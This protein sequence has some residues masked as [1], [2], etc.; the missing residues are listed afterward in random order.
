MGVF[1]SG[2]QKKTKDIADFE[3]IFMVIFHILGYVTR[4]RRGKRFSTAS[5]LY[6]KSIFSYFLLALLFKKQQDSSILKYIFL[7]E[8]ES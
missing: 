4:S 2:I 8:N 1:K 3:P 5:I 6:N 7:T